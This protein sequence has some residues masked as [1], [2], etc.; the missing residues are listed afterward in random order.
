MTAVSLEAL[1]EPD[2][3]IMFSEAIE[4]DGALVFA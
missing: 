2:G 1:I 4:V 3:A